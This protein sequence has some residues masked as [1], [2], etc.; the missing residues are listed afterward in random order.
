[1]SN[2]IKYSFVDLKDKDTY[3]IDYEKEEK[4][5]F[6]SF[7]EKK[8]EKP[9]TMETDGDD[10]TGESGE[11]EPGVPVKILMIFFGTRKK[12]QKNGQRKL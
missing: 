7:R 12:K 11:F 4:N 3:V 9:V 8:P 10:S 2:L 1:M 6:V 5:N